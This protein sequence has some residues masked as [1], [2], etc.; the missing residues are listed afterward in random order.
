MG[1]NCVHE[2]AHYVYVKHVYNGTVAGTFLGDGLFGADRTI[3]VEDR[4]DNAIK[5]VQK[6]TTAAK[7]TVGQTSR[8]QPSKRGIR[9]GGIVYNGG[10]HDYKNYNGDYGN[11]PRDQYNYGR[12]GGASGSYGNNKNGSYGKETGPRT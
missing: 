11:M 4:V 10:R 9:R 1:L 8:G 5:R 6:S 3:P 12:C 2:A 7:A